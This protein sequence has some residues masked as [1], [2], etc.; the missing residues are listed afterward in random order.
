MSSY[1]FTSITANYFAK[2]RILCTTLKEHNQDA[3][4]VLGIAD[5]LPEFIDLQKEPFDYVIYADSISSIENKD[6]FFFKHTVTELCTAVKPFIALEIIE[7]FNADKVIYLDPDIAVF[8]D[9]KEL[10]GLLDKYSI[11][12]TPHQLEPE[13]DD[14]YIIS[15]E[16][17]FLKRGTYNLGFFAVKAD[18]EGT[19]F[20]EWWRDRLEKYCFDDNYEL[21]DL[22]ERDHLLG[23][24]TDQKWMDLVPA[25]FN[26]Y[27]II[28][29]PGYN[30][31][32]WNMTRRVLKKGKDGL[33]YVNDKL[34]RFF[35][36]SGFDSKGHHN[37]MQR[38]CNYN[39]ENICAIDLTKWYEKQLHVHG[40][41]HFEKILWPY[42]QYSN[43]VTIQNIER[44]IFH[45]RKDIY[46][47]FTNPYE[48][49]D[50]FCYY[51]WVRQEYPNYFNN[52]NET[53]KYCTD[54]DENQ[55]RINVKKIID[56]VFP[57]LTKRRNFVKK[58][59]IKL[60]TI[61]SIKR[62]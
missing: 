60:R 47:F 7:R 17:L 12:L 58:I 55:N 13:D 4:F 38:A 9:F 23:M 5:K 36:F 41:E 46:K 39:P 26:N 62:G 44:K 45:I 18:R 19:S 56:W 8:S 35:H 32:T 27:Y 2:A 37:E 52:K 54:L 59:Y 51:N 48:V 11:L 25:F 15:N 16:I 33:F 31:C 49:N 61:R 21:I 34:L 42:S 29:D 24:F 10:E 28:K 43:R 22:L 20:L 30:V 40:Q 57:H 14:S 1:Y 53:D 50:G 3:I 6:I